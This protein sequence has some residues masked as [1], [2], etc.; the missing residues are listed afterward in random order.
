MIKRISEKLKKEKNGSLAIPMCILALT[1]I[2]VFTIQLTDWNNTHII[3][4]FEAASDLAA[5]E[6]LRTYID[7]KELRQERLELTGINGS[8]AERLKVLND[9]RDLYMEKVRASMPTGTGNVVRIEIPT[10][11]SGKIEI[12][13]GFDDSS[14]PLSSGG[15]WYGPV[16]VSPERTEYY[17]GG[18]SADTASMTIAKD[19]SGLASSGNKARTSYFIETKC[20][21]IY[22]TLGMF[23]S[24]A[25]WNRLNYVD[26]LTDNTITLD[27]KRIKNGMTAVTIQTMGKVT[28]R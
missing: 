26:I 9:I 1:L 7:E 18:H 21:V 6:S 20:T 4:S 2:A 8:E 23:D 25:T 3:R 14:F 5:V 24:G 12:P 10:I 16:V 27:T 11:V 28:L 17:L 13:D 15:T 22:K 19:T